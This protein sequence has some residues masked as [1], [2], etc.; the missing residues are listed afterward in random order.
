LL[1]YAIGGTL[2]LMSISLALLPDWPREWIQT[3]R[4]IENRPAFLWPWGAFTLLAA[5]RW[6]L[7]QGRLLLA[8]S[9][10]PL[11]ASWYEA[12]PLL[13]TATT[14][15]EYQS[16]SLISSVGYIAQSMFSPG[17]EFVAVR[18]TK[19]LL[20]IFCYLPALIVVLRHRDSR[21]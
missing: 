12:L 19:L 7:P 15:R 3:V 21:V 2:V 11:T 20:L 4:V 5:T 9:V 1:S 6:R 16:L 13:F 14:K 8:M 18:Y 10:V 17:Y